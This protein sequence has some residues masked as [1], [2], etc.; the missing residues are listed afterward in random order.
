[1]IFSYVKA[2]K[3]ET[4]EPLL[5]VLA[6]SALNC[7]RSGVM[8]VLPRISLSMINNSILNNDSARTKFMLFV[9]VLAAGAP[10]PVTH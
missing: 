3:G 1:M 6:T 7:K 8:A 4:R 9:K 10:R 5:L 2:D